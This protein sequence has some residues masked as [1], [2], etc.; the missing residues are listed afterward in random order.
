MRRFNRYV[1]IANYLGISVAYWL[2]F[3]LQFIDNGLSPF[4]WRFLLGFQW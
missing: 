1:F 3:G 4:R 2:D